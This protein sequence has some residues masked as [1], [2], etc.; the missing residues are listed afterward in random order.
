[1]TAE[2][3]QKKS[4]RRHFKVE[5]I[6][7][8]GFGLVILLG[9]LLLMLP[10]SAAPGQTTH[11]SD[12]LFTAVTSVCVTGL[13]TVPTALHWSLFGKVVILC[14]I[15]LGGLGII[16]CAALTLM[17]IGKRISMQ[18]SRLIAES[19]SLDTMDGMTGVIRR[20]VRGTLLVEAL[21]AVPYAVVFVPEYGIAGGIGR[22]V[23]NAVSCFCNA[24]MDILGEDSLVPWVTNKIINIDT[25]ILI[26]LGSIG[27][28]VWFDVID[29]LKKRWRR[30]KSARGFF[31]QLKLHSRMAIVVSVGLIVA[32]T[33]CIALF[34]WTNPASLG[35]LSAPDKVM[36]AA[37]QSVTTRT[38]GFQTIPQ[39]Q[40]TDASG[41]VS[42]LLMFIGGSPMGTA[43]GMKTTTVAVILLTV[44]AYCRGR[45]NTELYNRRLRASD[46]R[47][48]LVVLALGFCIA[49]T[50]IVALSA[51]SGAPTMDVLFEVISA[52]GTVGLSRGLT[53]T[54][55][56]AGKLILIV[57]MYCGRIGPVTLAMAVTVRAKAAKNQIRFPEEKIMIG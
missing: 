12:A 18:T 6:V 36:A 37:F 15:Q 53:P 2:T 54:L 46:I 34:D 28:F 14:L 47:T 20:I 5:R 7:A 56:V 21:G 44:G 25:M 3:N 4:Y 57:I 50:G 19:Y 32:G 29:T 23:F 26:F 10:V 51:V 27:F 16:A 39:Q 13:V 33:V 48:A 24:G 22:A 49:F 43:G 35:P 17:I 45:D 9:A 40:F 11:W 42:L 31:S 41:F 8:G 30:G 38:A 52:V 1:M 55:S